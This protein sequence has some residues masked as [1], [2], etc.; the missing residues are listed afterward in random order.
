[1]LAINEISSVFDHS[2]ACDKQIEMEC[3]PCIP[4]HPEIQTYALEQLCEQCSLYLLHIKCANWVERK[5]PGLMGNNH[6]QFHLTSHDSSSL[7]RPI[8]RECSIYQ[9]TG[10]EENLNQWFHK[11]KP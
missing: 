8:A 11:Q 1:M 2:A 3:N 6:S 5:W 9:R 10:T 4:L 7:Y